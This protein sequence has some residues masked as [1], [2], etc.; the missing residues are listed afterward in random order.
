MESSAWELCSGAGG[1]T[2]GRSGGGGMLDAGLALLCTAGL[3]TCCTCS[4]FV[5]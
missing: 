5:K 3:D 1:G 2:E 4:D